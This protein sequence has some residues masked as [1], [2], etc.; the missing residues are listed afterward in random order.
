MPVKP[1]ERKEYKCDC[2]AVEGQ[3]HEFGCDMERCPFC[4]GQ[5][6]SCFCLYRHLG[7]EDKQKYTSATS[8]LPSEIY[9]NG[10][11]DEQWAAWYT[12]CEKRGRFPYISYPVLCAMCGD[13][14]PEFFRVPDEEW[15]RFIEPRMRDKVICRPCYDYIKGVT[16]AYTTPNKYSE[17]E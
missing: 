12:L 9:E 4:G 11:T 1:D 5:L 8:Y 14:W 15:Q 6:V 2:G 16:L 13:L 17:I 10:V 3:L 7:I